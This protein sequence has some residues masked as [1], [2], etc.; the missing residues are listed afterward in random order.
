MDRITQE[1]YDWLL[2]QYNSRP[3]E[4]LTALEE[5]LKNPDLTTSEARILG[6]IEGQLIQM[7]ADRKAI[8]E[9]ITRSCSS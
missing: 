7:K 5:M 3:D 8:R 4:V 2:D 9:S 1:D 6:R